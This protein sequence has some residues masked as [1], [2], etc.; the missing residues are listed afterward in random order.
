MTANFSV[1]VVSMLGLF[2]VENAKSDRPKVDEQTLNDIPSYSELTE[3]QVA[4]V[5]QWRT[6]KKDKEVMEAYCR[7]IRQLEAGVPGSRRAAF[8]Y[9][10]SLSLK[11]MIAALS[12]ERA[13]AEQIA[14][15]EKFRADA[16]GKSALL[17]P[18]DK[19]KLRDA[20]QPVPIEDKVLLALRYEAELDCDR[21]RALLPS[22]D[23][24]ALKF[25][26]EML[27]FSAKHIDLFRELTAEESLAGKSSGHP[28]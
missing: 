16:E 24:T 23:T 19:K 21:Y 8:Y 3:G 7:P 9:S 11:G 4:A 17:S 27:K 20:F 5:L 15:F 25:A 2:I 13:K 22:V 1:F 28:I 14:W 18:G 12:A 6:G 26:D 10:V